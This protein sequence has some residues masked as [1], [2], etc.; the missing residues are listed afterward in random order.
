MELIDRRGFSRGL[1]FGAAA[2]GLALSPI[3]ARAMPLD[4]RL[5]EAA[6]RLDREDA[7]RWSSGRFRVAALGAGFG[8]AGGKGTPRLRLALGVV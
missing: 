6:R 8:V 1:L 7:R 4:D 3:A 5:P 2:A